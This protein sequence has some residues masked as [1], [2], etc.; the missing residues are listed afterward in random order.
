[1]TKTVDELE[2]NW[3]LAMSGAHAAWLRDRLKDGEVAMTKTTEEL[4]MEL[5]VADRVREVALDALD[6][7][8]VAT[9]AAMEALR[10]HQEWEWKKERID[11]ERSKA[12]DAL[13][14]QGQALKM[15]YE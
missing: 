4:R 3:R 2:A 9:Y 14:E 13:A 10:E 5:M 15:G 1:M 8:H 12:L 11:V 7:A 6:K